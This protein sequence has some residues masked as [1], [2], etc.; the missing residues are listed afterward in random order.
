[1]VLLKIMKEQNSRV[2]EKIKNSNSRVCKFFF[3]SFERR[4]NRNVIWKK[5]NFFVNNQLRRYCK[6]HIIL[7]P[8]TNLKREK[9]IKTGFLII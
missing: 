7:F 5:S 4:P 6:I 2:L 3:I 9:I 8:K 1:M